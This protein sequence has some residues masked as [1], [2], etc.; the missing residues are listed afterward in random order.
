MVK[1]WLFKQSQKVEGTDQMTQAPAQVPDPLTMTGKYIHDMS[2]MA[3]QSAG[4]M[5]RSLLW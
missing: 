3:L 5:K 4:D 2:S 1:A